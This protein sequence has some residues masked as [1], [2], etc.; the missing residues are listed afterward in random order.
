VEI[1]PTEIRE[2]IKAHEILI[3]KGEVRIHIPLVESINLNTI[4][5]LMGSAL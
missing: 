3:E 2:E 5:R 4:M 1:I